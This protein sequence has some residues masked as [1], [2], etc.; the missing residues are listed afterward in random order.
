MPQYKCFNFALSG[1]TLSYDYRILLEYEDNLQEEGI[2]F[3]PVSYFSFYGDEETDREDFETKNKRYYKFLSQRNIKNY[4]V[5]YDFVVKKFPVL[6][7]KDSFFTIF[8]GRAKNTNDL[9]WN[10]K[11]SDIDVSADAEGAYNR[12]F[13]VNHYNERKNLN[14]ILA[15]KNIISLCKKK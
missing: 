13:F 9:A 15:L 8:L 6:D 10:K 4:Q 7:Q 11:A 3:I 12:L 2:L 1:Q 5:F 14:E